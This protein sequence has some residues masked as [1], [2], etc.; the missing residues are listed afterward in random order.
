M[1]GS[2]DPLLLDDGDTLVD[3]NLYPRVET[4]DIKD[5]LV[6]GTS[7]Y[8]REQFKASMSLEAH[9]YLT[10]GWVSQPRLKVLPDKNVVCVAKVK[11]SQT[12]STKPLLP[13]VLLR[14]DGEVLTAHCTCMAGLAEACSHV[15]AILFYM[16]VVVRRMDSQACTDGENAWLPPTVNKLVCKTVAEID[17]GSASMKKRQLDEQAA[18]PPQ[19]LMKHVPR[20]S[21]AMISAFY[22]K[23]KEAPSKPA[24]LALVPGYSA[25][26]VPAEGRYKEVLLC[27]LFKGGPLPPWEDIEDDCEAFAS[28]LKVDQEVADKIEETTRTQHRSAK[29]FAFRSGRTTASTARAVCH[30]SMDAPALSLLKKI[31]HPEK[32]VFRSPATTWG[33]EHED[34]ARQLYTEVMGLSHPSFT[35]VNSGLLIR[36][37]LPFIAAT[38]DGATECSCCG[39]GLVEV[40]CPY[41]QRH[42]TLDE[43]LLSLPECLER[44][45][46]TGVVSLKTTH[47]YYYQV[48]TQ[49]LVAKKNH[50]DFAL[51]TIEAMFIERVYADAALHDEVVNKCK[52]F[53][54]KVVLPEL[55]YM[56]WSQAEIASGN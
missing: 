33:I 48:Q 19:K 28:S 52:T 56:F 41:L 45:E 7:F 29:W 31:C 36:P 2:V 26:Y 44:E 20:P 40:K 1:C 10:S 22:D 11:H 23:L 3:V 54:V 17:F 30:T 42:C 51:W 18:R 14:P 21:Q 32:C 6:N 5:Y 4:T 15:A 53:F 35:C 46:S 43:L 9:N 37:D 27:N 38:P 47:T 8:S 13:W 39:L 55:L 12:F 24:L 50:C 16:E 25:P 34:E 49:M